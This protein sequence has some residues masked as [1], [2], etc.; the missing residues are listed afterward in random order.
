[1]PSPPG[2]SLRKQPCRRQR[3]PPDLSGTWG[4]LQQPGGT[5]H[6]GVPAVSAALWRNEGEGMV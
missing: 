5:A 1:L 6:R 3:L 4:E 2:A